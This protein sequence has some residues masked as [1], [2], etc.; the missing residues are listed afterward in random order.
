MYRSAAFNEKELRAPC[1]DILGQLETPAAQPVSDQAR[2][3]EQRRWVP[4]NWIKPSD[5]IGPLPSP[6][7]VIDDSSGTDGWN[8]HREKQPLPTSCLEPIR[9]PVLDADQVARDIVRPGSP[10]LLQIQRRF[11]TA[12]ILNP[13]GH[14]DRDSLR[15][16]ILSD[17]DAKRD[18][19]ALTHPPIQ[20]TIQRWMEQQATDGHGA[21]IVEAALLIEAGSYS[22][23]D[24]LVVVT[25]T[26]NNNSNAYCHAT[27]FSR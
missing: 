12:D 7:R 25:C 1:A 22:T 3:G 23:Y 27:H 19:E 20:N 18:L 4:A 26:A 24:L 10:T 6:I 21:A 11:G 2:Q 8:R 17:A 16:I 13:S 14:L 5:R 15:H 9:Y